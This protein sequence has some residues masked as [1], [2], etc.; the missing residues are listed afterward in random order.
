MAHICFALALPPFWRDIKTPGASF[1]QHDGKTATQNWTENL[2]F[3]AVFIHLTEDVSETPHWPV[4][5]AGLHAVHAGLHGDFS[6]RFV[7]PVL[8]VTQQ[9]EATQLLAPRRQQGC[10]DDTQTHICARVS[11]SSTHTHT[12]K[13]THLYKYRSQVVIDKGY[14]WSDR[15]QLDFSIFQLKCQPQTTVFTLSGVSTVQ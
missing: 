10:K 12:H 14:E 9:E 11:L 7:L 8:L 15:K 2:W 4:C 3:T 13:H 1:Y 5:E 6:L